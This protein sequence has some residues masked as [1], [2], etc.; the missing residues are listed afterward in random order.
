[1]FKVYCIQTKFLVLFFM[2]SLAHAAFAQ[3]PDLGPRRN[4]FTPGELSLLPP[5]CDTRRGREQWRGLLGDE[6]KHIH[7]YCRGLRDANFAKLAVVTQAQRDFLWTRATTEYAYMIRNSR[8]DNPV[9]PEMHFH[10]GEAFLNLRKYDAADADFTEARKLKPDYIP[11]YTLWVDKLFEM[12]LYSRAKV[13]LEEG[14]KHSPRSPELN[15]RLS[16]LSR[17]PAR[18]E[19]A[20]SE[21]E[22]LVSPGPTKNEPAAQEPNESESSK[23]EQEGK[24]QQ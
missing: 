15:E 23:A 8:P 5:Y 2:L 7:H 6:V 14:I 13:I 11:A 9:L 19:S 16:R 3:Q 24:V 22:P 18:T 20:V 4:T 17:T 12:K 21:P 1:M 10:R